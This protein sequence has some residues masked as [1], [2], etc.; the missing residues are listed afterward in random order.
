MFE[1]THRDKDGLFLEAIVHADTIER[2]IE[3]FRGSYPE[4]DIYSVRKSS[5]EVI[6]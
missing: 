5:L 1:I 6:S 2:A 4:A 3:I